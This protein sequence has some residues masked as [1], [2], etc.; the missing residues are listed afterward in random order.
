MVLPLK[1][2]P[3]ISLM[4][5]F[6]VKVLQEK[7]NSVLKK[8][9]AIAGFSI[10]AFLRQFLSV[11]LLWAYKACKLGPLHVGSTMGE[12]NGWQS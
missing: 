10:T 9:S 11:G 7:L 3:V 8:Q 12:K 2:Q 1:S 4:Q 6:L 5:Y